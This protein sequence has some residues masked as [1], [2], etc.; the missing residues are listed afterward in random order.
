MSKSYTH[1][2][3]SILLSQPDAN[4]VYLKITDTLNFMCYE[5]NL[6][7]SDFKKDFTVADQYAIIQKCFEQSSDYEVIMTT[8]SGNLKLKFVA[9]IGK[10][11]HFELVVFVK[12][13]IL[14]GDGRLT[15]DFNRMEQK[16]EMANQALVKRCDAL[17]KRCK[18]LEEALVK[19]GQEFFKII[20]RLDILLFAHATPNYV[21]SSPDQFPRAMPKISSEE[22]SIDNAQE[23]G[24]M[25]LENL[26]TFYKLKKLRIHNFPIKKNL[27]SMANETLTELELNCSGAGTF[28]SLTGFENF[29]N[30]DKLTVMSAPGLTNVVVVLK[31]KPHKIKTLKFQGC[32][33]INVVE[34]QTYCQ[35]NKIFV[36]LS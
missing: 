18:G 19:Q 11:L 20:D 22:I 17:E 7:P 26:S 10:I 4:T 14:S 31:S 3:F 6:Q 15:L 29:P 13:K 35:E 25:R 33:G 28:T 8:T 24:Q 27:A 30:L 34:L 23:F 9:L 36:A 1:G 21:I 2:S 5:G 32:P 16:Q 12:E